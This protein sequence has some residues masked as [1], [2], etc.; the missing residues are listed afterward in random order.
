MTYDWRTI[1]ALMC[2]LIAVV[3]I[4]SN[5][6]AVWMSL[7]RGRHVSWV[8]LVGGLA[9]ASALLLM[10]RTKKWFWI[11]FLV[12][13][14]SAPVAPHWTPIANTILSLVRESMS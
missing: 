3:V 8:P 13:W 14:G 10:R 9:G 4:A 5:Y 1:P 6:R 12:D 7:V 11:A 2:A